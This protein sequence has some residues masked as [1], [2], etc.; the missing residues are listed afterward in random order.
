MGVASIM[1]SNSPGGRPSRCSGPRTGTPDPAAASSGWQDPSAG[2]GM[3]NRVR[4][5]HSDKSAK[6]VTSHT[7]A[8]LALLVASGSV[9][10][11][12]SAVSHRLGSSFAVV[13][14]ADTAALRGRRPGI[15]W[16]VPAGHKTETEVPP[17]ESERTTSPLSPGRG[18]RRCREQPRCRRGAGRRRR[19]RQLTSRRCR[20]L[21]RIRTEMPGKGCRRSPHRNR[22]TDVPNPPIGAPQLT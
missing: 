18:R 16:R 11:C 2:G 22:A 9:R 20:S 12:S 1:R 17:A 3:I 19:R 6:L 4:F 8:V 7:A 10:S 14:A 5:G 21:R 15:R 13:I